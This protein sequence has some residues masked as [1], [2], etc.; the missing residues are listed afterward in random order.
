VTNRNHAQGAETERMVVKY[1]RDY[2]PAVDRR[3]REGRA[4]DQGDLDGVPFTTVQVKRAKQ[5]RLQQWVRQTLDQRERAGNPLCL[6]IV[7]KMHKPVSQWDA[8]LP[9]W[10]LVD[11]A[12]D[13]SEASAWVRMDLQLAVVVINHLRESH[14]RSPLSS[15]T[16]TSS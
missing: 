10:Y 1:L 8:Y 14:T 16:T 2:W 9:A 7:R 5:L 12:V 15:P 6:L 3:L 4:D 11:I 13:E